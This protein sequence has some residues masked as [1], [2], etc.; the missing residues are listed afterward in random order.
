MIGELSLFADPMLEF[1]DA[2]RRE[3]E[4]L[5]ARE[6]ADGRRLP[7]NVL[8]R[9]VFAGTAPAR[10]RGAHAARGCLAQGKM[11]DVVHD[12]L[13]ST[14]R[15]TGESGDGVMEGGQKLHFKITPQ[16]HPFRGNSLVRSS[17]LRKLQT[18]HG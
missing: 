4:A 17:V 16:L 7:Y 14:L 1:P 13:D 11:T 6:R 12:L 15:A 8:G 5:R 9:G 10:L 2:Q 18:G 3:Q